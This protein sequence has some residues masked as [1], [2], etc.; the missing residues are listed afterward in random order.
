MDTSKRIPPEREMYF[1]KLFTSGYSKTSEEDLYNCIA[2]AAGEEYSDEC[3]CPY[4][5]GNGYYWPD[6]LERNAEIETFV[7]LY[8]I[9]CG[10]EPC[11]EN[12]QKLE[13]GVEKIA[14][15]ADSKKQITHVARQLEDGTWTSKLGD[16][17]DINHKVLEGLTGNLFLPAYGNFVRILKR[18][19]QLKPV[20][21]FSLTKALPASRT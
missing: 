2:W 7:Q 18:N 8:R 3:W 15:Y 13:A 16:W 17:E 4:R 21:T 14:L 6:G 9:K 20:L 12:S 5:I 1:P 11:P 19:H 10:Y